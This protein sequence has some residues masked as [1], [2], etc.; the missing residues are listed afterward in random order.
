M[1]RDVVYGRLSMTA[2]TGLIASTVGAA[3]FASDAPAL[4]AVGIALYVAVPAIAGAWVAAEGSA[5][6]TAVA[7]LASVAVAW[8]FTA[9]LAVA[10]WRALSLEMGSSARI[11]LDIAL[12]APVVV[13]VMLGSTWYAAA[14]ERAQLWSFVLWIVAVAI[15]VLGQPLAYALMNAAGRGDGSIAWYLLGPVAAL[16]IAVGARSALAVAHVGSHRSRGEVPA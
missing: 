9:A 12:W 3:L 13:L 2:P 6:R 10:A 1:R 15:G 4:T 8:G 11:A 14:S 5:A 7:S 16:G